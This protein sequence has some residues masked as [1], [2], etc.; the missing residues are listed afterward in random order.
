MADNSKE[1]E[2]LEQ[3][4]TDK[5]SVKIQAIVK[6]ARV[7]QSEDALNAV[8]PL[9]SIDDRELSFFATQAA[10]K[11]SQKLGIN[12][13]D[14]LGNNKSNSNAST[15]EINRDTF[16]NADQQ[17]APKLLKII[18]ENTESLQKDWL[19]AIGYFLTK[20]GSNEDSSFIKQQLLNDNSNLCLPFLNAAEH[21]SKDILPEI[22]PN[23]LASQESLVRSRAI[24]ILQK[25]DPQE[26]ENHFADL[27]V[28][29][30]P[31]NRL[32]GVGL[33]MMFPF[34]RVKTYLISLLAN[35]TDKDVISAC[36][37]VLVSNPDKE[38]A[39]K[40]LDKY[41]TVS[42]AHKNVLSHVFKFVCK[43]IE[44]TKT[45]PPNE[46][47]PESII[48]VWKKSRLEKFLDNIEI[49]LSLPDESK[50]KP[51]IE[52][53]QKNRSNSKVEDFIR[54]LEFNPQAENIYRSLMGLPSIE[55][56]EAIANNAS[57]HIEATHSETLNNAEQ[58]QDEAIT[59]DVS[60]TK[61]NSL[62]ETAT[63]EQNENISNVDEN[64][65]QQETNETHAN[66]IQE[67]NQQTKEIIKRLK[68]VD[69]ENAAENKSWVLEIAQ[70]ESDSNPKIKAE[71]INAMLRAYR[72]PK[73]I[74]IAKKNIYS[75][76]EPV[77]V[78]SFKVLERTNPE[79]LQANLSNFL[80]EENENIRVR[81]VRFAIKKDSQTAVSCLTPMLASNNDKT[82]ASAVSCLGL[83]PFGQ[84]AKLLFN[85]LAVE[86]HPDIAKQITNIILN[87]PSQTILEALDAISN[88]N[89]EIAMEICQTRNSLDALVKQ[90]P[91]TSEPPESKE[92]QDELFSELEN[93]A[94]KPY[95]VSNVRALK[96]KQVK[97]KE[98][99]QRKEPMYYVF[100]IASIV[101]IIGT[102]AIIYALITHEPESTPKS[103]NPKKSSYS[104]SR[105]GRQNGVSIKPTAKV[106]DLKMNRTNKISAKV[107][108][109]DSDINI[110]IDYKGSKI[111]VRFDNPVPRK[112]RPKSNVD[113]TVIPYSVNS[114]KIVQARGQNLS[115]LD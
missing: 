86:E 67:E 51:I 114:Q 75:Q 80:K 49:T 98:K 103:S 76:S 36:Q 42:S 55:E 17:N 25:I 10:G 28:S 74:E 31:E 32:A 77:K 41:D 68:N 107:I 101:I 88:P 112:L 59:I 14:Y 39:L 38:T 46:S 111:Y 78:A 69:L 65:I 54:K 99:N 35:E 7:G 29:N 43:A 20:Y 30:N 24:S 9:M 63:Y 22:L 84:T 60:E 90:M 18:R 16:L 50:K 40:I 115:V 27:L 26:A 93:K 61:T 44:I 4:N 2:I 1:K 81:A 62:P 5:R 113:L 104:S 87:N 3:L 71:A 97:D 85:R 37:T 57:I 105:G 33:A 48:T 23:L 58:I 110:L 82:R 73:L 53:L 95:S 34:E 13:S 79:F 108:S 19:P 109:I 12:L 45:L 102:S 91:Q 70:D 6:L 47:K 52:W 94:N 100:M 106:A 64:Q 96:E 83:C 92:L 8:I 66:N 56:E 72:G 89:P 21:Y 11:I 15:D